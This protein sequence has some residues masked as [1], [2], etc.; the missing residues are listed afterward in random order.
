ML[1]ERETLTVRLTVLICHALMLKR[2]FPCTPELSTDALRSLVA[3]PVEDVIL[4]EI[5]SLIGKPKP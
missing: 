2:I 5:E 4:K 3:Y 1:T